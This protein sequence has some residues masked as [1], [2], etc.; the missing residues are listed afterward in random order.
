MSGRIG[1]QAAFLGPKGTVADYNEPTLPLGTA[2]QLGKIFEVGDKKYRLVKFSEASVAATVGKVAYWLLKSTY[3]VT[4]DESDGEA[5]INGIC[6]GF[7]GT[8]TNGNYCFV[9]CGG[10]Q[11]AVYVANSTVIGDCLGGGTTDGQLER[12]PVSTFVALPVAV[13]LSNKSGD[14][15]TVRWL[16]D[17]LQ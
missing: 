3:T 9:Q 5:L 1:L 6:G 8:I 13:A 12:C 17:V 11:T 2:G 4:S 7:L 14:T 10:D 15:A 16:P